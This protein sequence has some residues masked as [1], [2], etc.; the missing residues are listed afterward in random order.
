MIVSFTE[1]CALFQLIEFSVA[2]FRSFKSR[3]TL[4][5]VASNKLVSRDPRLDAG[6]T[7]RVDDDLVLLKGAAIYGANASGKSNLLTAVRFMKGMVLNSS[8]ETAATQ[9]I[10][11]EPFR[12]GESNSGPSHFEVVFLLQDT[13]YRYGFEADSRSIHAEWLFAKLGPR[14]TKLFT[15]RG[16]TFSL[17]RAE[18]KE[19]KGLEDRT[20]PN[21]LFLSVVAQFN[22]TVALRLQRWFAES[23]RV[24]SGLDDE[25]YRN[26]TV[27][28]CDDDAWRK[29]ILEF[30]RTMDVGI[31][32]LSVSKVPLS[33]TL[34][35]SMPPELR[36]L[37]VTHS[38]QEISKVATIHTTF[39]AN[40]NPVGREVFDIQSHES[41][42]TK[43]V[44]ALAGPVLDTLTKGRVLF[45]DELDARLHPLITMSLVRL[46]NSEATN[47]Q[48]AQLVFTTHDTNILQSDL[49]RRDQIWF[50]EKDR[51]G[52][53]SVYSLLEYRPRNDAS[54]AK[55]YIHG[56]YGAV[57]FVGD[58]NELVPAGLPDEA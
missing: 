43:K 48:Q 32:D 8:K 26:Y 56:R 58:L 57:P 39:D 4:S 2:N 3:A 47:P 15:R 19:G 33:E 54:L 36:Q 34:P 49:L 16:S 41:E 35:A 44:F 7:F 22:G 10:S 50:T 28:R 21:A 6:S 42:G 9:P 45:V 14:E 31:D 18:F 25:G 1:D 53:T 46:F 24:I 20:R 30:V 51:T 29:S 52:S 27:A 38:E 17:S 37:L 40:G 13:T 12:L 11:V 5:L 23:L 55:N